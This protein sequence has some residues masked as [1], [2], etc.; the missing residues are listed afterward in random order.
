MSD[1]STTQIMMTL[2]ALAPDGATPRPSG[3]TPAQHVARISRGITAQL[4]ETGL[5]TQGQIG[6]AH[7]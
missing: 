3:E 7:V 5:A 6:R 4:A 2:A 1:Y